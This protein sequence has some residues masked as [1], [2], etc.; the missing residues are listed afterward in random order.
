M[1]LSPPEPDELELSVFG[2]G[3]GESICVHLGS[4][5]WVLVDSCINPD[6]KLPAALSY[7]PSLGLSPAEAVRLVIATHWDD[8]HI[9]G[10]GEVVEACVGARVACSAALGMPDIV[11]FV[12]E[13]EAAKGALG[14]GLDAFRTLLRVCASRGTTILWAKAN[15]P[16][17]PLPP[18]DTPAVI[19]LSPSE[20]AFERSIVSLV[21]AAA[22]AKSTFR[23]RYKA[24]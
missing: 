2:R 8:D 17:H 1:D 18:G 22:Q 6:T 9:G 13:Q 5:D 10:I 3:Y 7:L 14:S 11:A 24:P 4:G 16:L 12:F 19:A 15:L 20:D 23:R 21:E